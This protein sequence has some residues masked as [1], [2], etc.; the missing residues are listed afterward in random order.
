MGFGGQDSAFDSTEVG[1]WS[2]KSNISYKS[3]THGLAVFF[4][5]LVPVEKVLYRLVVR[6]RGGGGFY[7]TCKKTQIQN[8]AAS[9]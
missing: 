6:P 4:F 1:L 8:A 5:F 9:V 7:K 3:G 2:V